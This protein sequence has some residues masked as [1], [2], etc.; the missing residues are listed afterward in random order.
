MG[1]PDIISPLAPFGAERHG[2]MTIKQGLDQHDSE[3]ADLLLVA[4]RLAEESQELVWEVR[5]YTR[6]VSAAQR[7]IEQTLG[8]LINP[9]KGRPC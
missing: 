2:E 4:T 7:R 8:S 1:D 3:I 6:E 9:T 5:E